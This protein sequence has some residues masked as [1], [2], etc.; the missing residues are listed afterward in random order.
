MRAWSES[1]LG[2]FESKRQGLVIQALKRVVNKHPEINMHVGMYPRTAYDLCPQRGSGESSG[3]EI[4]W[5]G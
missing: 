1:D 5:D 2:W 4:G 3:D